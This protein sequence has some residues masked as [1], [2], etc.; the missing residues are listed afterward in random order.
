MADAP[1]TSSAPAEPSGWWRR[2]RFHLAI[3]AIALGVFAATSADRMATQ[4][5]GPHFVYQ[6]EAFLAGQAAL[7]SKPP[8]NNDW[9]R[10]ES[11]D[12][13][14]FPPVPA[15][16]MLPG[17]A[18]WGTAF[19]DV[20]FTLPWAALNVLLMFLVLQMLAR[21]GLSPMS[22]Q[23]NLW[24]CA[25][26]GFGTVHYSCAVLGEV[27]FTAQILGV[28]F[29]LAYIL[30]ATRARHPLLAGIF[31]ALAFDT[32]VNLAFTA[33]YFVLQLVLPRG[34]QGQPAAG[35][36]RAALGKLAVFAAPILAVGAAQ[37][38]FNYVRFHSLFEFGHSYL[39]G[40]A[41][42]R[43]QQHGLFAFHYLEWNLRSLL[44]RLPIT[45]ERFPWIGYNADGM[46]IFMTTPIFVW[47]FWPRAKPWLY[48]I[49]WASALPALAV[50]LFYQNSGYVQFGYRFALDI[51]PYLVMLLAV[52]RLPMGRWTKVF[53][54]V[55]IAVNLAGAI[56]FKRAGPI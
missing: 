6:A 54:L 28:S 33:G 35:S 24:L 17:V 38:A 22:R 56:A 32:R 55:G 19:N 52:G 53:I 29:T 40:P 12:Y 2:H 18:I 26:F 9:I 48:P 41:G 44:L 14:S 46:S 49:L 23:E 36:W 3:F 31:L 15:V 20:L 45:T 27:W 47:L 37:M 51:T 4:S 39:Q 13:V 16:F 21:E 34:P 10:Y 8:N 50:P 42:N 30:A 5:Q 7:V 43:I 11:K 1:A 25:L